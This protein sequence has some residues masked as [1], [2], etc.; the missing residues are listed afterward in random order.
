M[1]RS[2]VPKNCSKRLLCS[3]EYNQ[4]DQ[5][6]DAA[7]RSA[8]LRFGVVIGGRRYNSTISGWFADRGSS[9]PFL[10]GPLALQVSRIQ[11]PEQVQDCSRAL[12]LP[13][14]E[15]PLGRISLCERDHSL[16]G[17]ACRYL[18]RAAHNS[19]PWLG[20]RRCTVYVGFILSTP[21]SSIANVRPSCFRKFCAK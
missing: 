10:G 4:T 3:E 1:T 17:V 2:C 12:S 18:S 16:S 9:I 8:E 20:Q 15:V 11:V 21:E 6:T 7:A 19:H 13:V 14:T 5:R